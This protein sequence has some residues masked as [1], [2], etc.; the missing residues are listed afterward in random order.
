MEEQ[1]A[2]LMVAFSQMLTPT[3]NRDN[4]PSQSDSEPQRPTEPL[5]AYGRAAFAFVAPATATLIF[6]S[7]QPSIGI[8][9]L[10]HSFHS[11]F[12]GSK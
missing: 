9:S 3:Q 10:V 7:K 6:R 12:L 4:Q 5:C 2:Q 11:V 8:D 1:I